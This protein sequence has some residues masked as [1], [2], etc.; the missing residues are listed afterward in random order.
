LELRA[1]A[2]AVVIASQVACSQLDCREVYGE[3]AMAAPHLKNVQIENYRIFNRFFIDKFRRLNLI[4]GTNGTGKTTLLEAI[5]FLMDR[6]NIISLLRP[7]QWRQLPPS[8]EFARETLFGSLHNDTIRLVAE[9]REGRA[10]VEYKWGPQ[11]LPENQVV[12]I[13]KLEIDRRSEMDAKSESHDIGFSVLVKSDNIVKMARNIIPDIGGIKILEVQNDLKK[14]PPAVMLSRFTMHF[15]NDLAERYSSIARSGKK[16]KVV[17]I[18]QRINPQIQ[19]VE[20]F[21]V[22]NAPL[23]HVQLGK[24]SMVPASFAGDGVLTMLSI[25]LAIMNCEKGVVILDEFDAAIHYSQL[26]TVWGFIAEMA[27]EYDCQIFAATHSRECI[28]A[29]VQGVTDKKC[30][31]DFAYFRLDRVDEEIIPT[32]YDAD[33]I[34]S[35][36]QNDWE[37]R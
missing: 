24:G 16:E 9:T 10:E 17:E 19:G 30:Q 6:G 33:E 14:L 31:S 18:A 4:A 32:A 7:L 13:G 8:L 12:E 29:A 20:L 22:G 21:Q 3:I 36:A 27:R 11:K 34:I 26:S 2:F 35:A 23:L 37:M 1:S 25:G 15:A 28:D 5:F